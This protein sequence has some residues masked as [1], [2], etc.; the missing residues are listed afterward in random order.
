MLDP[1]FSS[2]LIFKIDY[3]ILEPLKTDNKVRIFLIM[4]AERT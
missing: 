1:F 2:I 3:L 4:T